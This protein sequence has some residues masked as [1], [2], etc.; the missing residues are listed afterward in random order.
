[1]EGV[2]DLSAE[3][4]RLLD[5]VIR[6]LYGP[7]SESW[8]KLELT[9]TLTMLDIIHLS[10]TAARLGVCSLA[11]ALIQEFHLHLQ[12]SWNTVVSPA[13]S[14]EALDDLV[15]AVYDDGTAG[16]KEMRAPLASHVAERV[17]RCEEDEYLAIQNVIKHHDS[18]F[19]VD[20][21]VCLANSRRV[22]HGL[23]RG[24]GQPWDLS[25]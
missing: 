25:W 20:V 18:A 4:E 3:D 15:N 16:S 7:Y 24:D 19:A 10:E 11:H 21:A 6:W 23:G 2:I 22:V 14:P 8:S 9:K 1:L 17:C 5:L 13:V 12:E